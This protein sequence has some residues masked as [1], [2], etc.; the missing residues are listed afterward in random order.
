MAHIR[1]TDGFVT[2]ALTLLS[3]SLVG[4]AGAVKQGPKA[5]TYHGPATVMGAGQA[6]TF[7]TID[8]NGRPAAIG[9]K[10]SETALLGLPTER[11]HDVP[12]W[13]YPLPLPSEAGVAG[14][15]H[16]VVNWNPKGHIPPGAY[17]APHFDFHF[18]LISPEQRATI[19]A[20]GEDRVRAQKMP[21]PDYMPTGYQLPEGTEEPRMGA[22][23]ID[24]S[25]PEFNNLPFTKSF[26]YGFYDGRMIFVEPMITKAFLETKT[27]AT[28]TVKRPKKF[29][30]QAYYPTRYSVTYD[31]AKQEYAIALDGLTSSDSMDRAR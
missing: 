20:V 22:H 24:P 28:E 17:D 29:Q 4:C 9:V 27:N 18:Y 19:T 15:K 26:I 2:L 14:Y 30:Q 1:I 5:G 7:V 10:M 31:A 12:G 21:E 13:E 3:I 11:P 6:R 23:A 16:I 8:G 25:A